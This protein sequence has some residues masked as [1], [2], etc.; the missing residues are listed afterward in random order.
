MPNM[1]PDE[2]QINHEIDKAVHPMREE[3]AELKKEL[4]SVRILAQA[5]MNKPSGSSFHGLET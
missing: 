1:T 5:A 2:I 4:E 3:I